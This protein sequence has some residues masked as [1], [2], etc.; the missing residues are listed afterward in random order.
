MH[1]AGFDGGKVMPTNNPM[2]YALE[3]YVGSTFTLVGDAILPLQ[4]QSRTKKLLEIIERLGLDATLT[5]LPYNTLIGS[6]R[7]SLSALDA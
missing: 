3:V 1:V 5:R 4:M 2:N 6:T 7:M